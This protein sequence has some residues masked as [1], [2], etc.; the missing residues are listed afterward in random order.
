[1]V[2]H[3]Y[4]HWDDGE[5]RG[6]LDRWRREVYTQH[7]GE[8]CA[9]DEAEASRRLLAGAQWFRSLQLPL[10]GFVAPAW[11]LGEGGWAALRRFGLRYT[12]TLSSL[13]LLPE[14]RAVHSQ[15]LVY[16]ARSG[17]RR[18]AS[19]EWNRVCAAA[20]AQRPLLRLELHPHDADDARM[21][22]A[23]QHL[24]EA[25]LRERSAVTLADAAQAFRSDEA[26]RAL[27][28][29][30]ADGRAD[31]HVARIVQPEHHAR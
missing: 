4:T 28:H 2:L 8:F 30:Q 7:E 25:A 6:A 26:Q 21:R 24:L 14:R 1:V 9:L 27:G 15:S 16:S 13:V 22:R 10:R 29:E 3:G 12:C 18:A 31:H 11:L 19:I 5:P 20:Q 23:W 17:W